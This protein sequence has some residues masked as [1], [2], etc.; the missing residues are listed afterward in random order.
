[1]DAIRHATYF[2]PGDETIPGHFNP[3]ELSRDKQED[4][5]GQNRTSRITNKTDSVHGTE[6]ADKELGNQAKL[7]VRMLGSGMGTW[8]PRDELCKCDLRPSRTVQMDGEELPRCD[9]CE[10]FFRGI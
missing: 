10:G 5:Q 9:R 1:M 6:N 3:R 7:L 2:F 4:E 8:C